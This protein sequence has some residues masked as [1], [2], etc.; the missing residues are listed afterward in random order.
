MEG[1][2]TAT[3]VTLDNHVMALP[4]DIIT[5]G[6][7]VAMEFSSLV[8]DKHMIDVGKGFRLEYSVMG[9]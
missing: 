6:E 8:K 7:T 5:S 9:K 3:V 4:N 2:M 1:N